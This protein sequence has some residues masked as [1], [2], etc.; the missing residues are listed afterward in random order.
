MSVKVYS[1]SM[2]KRQSIA[3]ENIAKKKRAEEVSTKELILP[4]ENQVICVVEEVIGADHVRVRCLDGVTRV[5]RIPGKF[6]RRVWL[7]E[8]DIV[9]VT[10]WDFQPNRGDIAHKYDKDEVRKLLNM[11]VIP[12][13]FLES[14]GIE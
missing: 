5:C 4:V 1:R 14:L 11:G 12:R 9:L 6:R 10:P 8:G 2:S 3:G 7:S 13:E